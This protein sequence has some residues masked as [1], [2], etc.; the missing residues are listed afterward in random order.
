MTYLLVSREYRKMVKCPH[1]VKCA[2]SFR[3]SSMRPSLD[4]WAHILLVDCVGSGKV[5]ATSVFDDVSVR[6][7]LDEFHNTTIGMVGNQARSPVMF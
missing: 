4:R 3:R 5:L 6:T 7:L 2:L 1:S